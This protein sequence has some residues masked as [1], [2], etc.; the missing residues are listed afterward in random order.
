MW[1][2][3]C[4]DEDV[5]VNDGGAVA[6]AVAD[7]VAAAVAVA[8]AAVVVVAVKPSRPSRRLPCTVVITSFLPYITDDVDNDAG[9]VA[10]ADDAAVDVDGSV[11]ARL[12]T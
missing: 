8:V 3:V 4:D 1:V 6:V 11:C 9:D 2:C 10:A 12:C 5:D 7:A